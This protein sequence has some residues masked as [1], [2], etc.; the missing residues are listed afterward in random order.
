[1]LRP[2]LLEFLRKIEPYY[3]V[4]IFTCALKVYADLILDHLPVIS[5]RLYRQ[6]AVK[7]GNELIKDLSRVGRDISKMI[8]VDN[9]D[10]N[11]KLQK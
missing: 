7:M 6:H 8:L 3:E 5:F 11:Y 1:M 2:Y 4:G 10:K 9:L